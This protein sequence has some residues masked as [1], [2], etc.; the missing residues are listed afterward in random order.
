MSHDYCINLFY[1]FSHLDVSAMVL[2]EH[3][4]SSGMNEEGMC[5]STWRYVYE[6]SIG[7]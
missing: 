7:V 6:L 5:H 2:C 3:L 4:S 1:S